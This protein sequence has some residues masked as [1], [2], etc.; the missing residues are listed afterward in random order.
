MCLRLVAWDMKTIKNPCTMLFIF[1]RYEVTI[2]SV[3]TRN[4]QTESVFDHMGILSTCIFNKTMLLK[5]KKFL[6]K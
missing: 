6:C 4:V 5:K 1:G 3:M 2:M